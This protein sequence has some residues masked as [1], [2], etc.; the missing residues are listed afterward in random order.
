MK[1]GGLLY[2]KK[3]VRRIYRN[4]KARRLSKKDVAK[5]ALYI[6]GA[7]VLFT[8]ILFAW[9]SKDLPTPSKLASLR[10]KESTKILDRNGKLL[11][12]TGEQKRTV[13]TKEQIPDNVKKAT[14]AVEDA[15]FY[16]HGGIDF[17]GIARAV[18]ADIF[19]RNFSQGASTITQQYVKN[20]ILSPEK[21]VAR[22]VKEVILSIELE[23]LYSKDEIL[24]MYLNEIPY[25]G[26]IYGVEAASQTFFGKPANQLSLSEA[27]TL[28]AIPQ[29]PT[30]FSPYG[31]HTDALFAR[32]NLVLDRMVKAGYVTQPEAD[33]TKEQAPN[34]KEAK[35]A[36]RTDTIIA[37]HFVMYV[38]DVLAD[39]YGEQL[40]NS[41]G[42]T[43]TTTL[44]IEKQK[45]AQ[46]AIDETVPKLDRYNATNASLVSIDNKTGE[47][48]AMVGGKDYFDLEH[49]GNVNVAVSNRQPGSSFKPI[50]YATAFKQARYNPAFVLYDLGTD[51]GGYK[52]NNYNGNFNGPVTIRTALSN[53][54]NIPAVK[55]LGLVGI[56]DAIQTAKDLGITT[57]TQPERYGLSLVLGGG[58]VKLLELTGAYSA[59]GDSGNFHKP[60]SVLKVQDHREKVL[61]EYK[62]EKNKFQ[63]LDPQVAYEITSV[64]SDNNA[65]S[66]I[67]GPR[68]SLFFP[69]RHVAVKTG[70]TQSFHDA[71]TVGY[72]PSITA[73][74]WVGNNDNT[75]MR[76]G[77][78]GSVLAGP[79]FNK[80][81][82][83]VLDKDEE[84]IRPEGIQEITVD[85][86]SNKLPGQYSPENERIK[87]IFASYQVPTKF[88]DIHALFKV[89]K[90]N[91]KL[92]TDKTPSNLV[93]E[94]LFTNLHNE[95]GDKW[96]DYPNWEG[97]IRSWALGS[98]MNLTPSNEDDDSYSYN[99][100]VQIINPSNGASVSGTISI[101]VSIK[102]QYNVG[103]IKY[104][105]GDVQIGE[106]KETSISL[107]TLNYP[108]GLYTI[109]AIFEDENGVSSD[110][111]SELNIKNGAAIEI[112]SP[113][114][115]GI[116][117]SSAIIGFSTNITANSTIKYGTSQANLTGQKTSGANT[118]SHQATLTGLTPNTTYYFL[119][120]TSNSTRSAQTQGS[121]KTQ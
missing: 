66:M 23:Q 19:N 118:T 58:E 78:D 28:A 85:K 83:K 31:S 12:E 107:N 79:I 111:Q 22:K 89:N 98:G 81:M 96:K 101:Q 8:V 115:S 48:L 72:S 57:L 15:N 114:A 3:D 49:D 75:P 63:A 77:A 37:P 20:A 55:M 105:L 86:L 92:A 32:K 33:K 24:T 13:I 116:T 119:I 43:V 5:I 68:S 94:K 39:Q 59:F 108:D 69:D 88:D 102:S 121:F 11:Y 47:V 70:T 82:T 44:D 34:K 95:W 71:W 93:E 87:D 73:G 84:F 45:L 29:A 53:S 21:S 46:E 14:I 56:P 50:V 42:L 1:P 25:G 18:Y 120:E 99:P 113:A 2:I 62:K 17:R 27:A 97:P 67:F 117:A 54:L 10:A 64:L 109:K 30:R 61:F 110:A 16:K 51:F 91:N 6:V 100:T 26:N 38:K 106:T 65:R 76:G 104:R 103:S 35:F 60:T 41:G 36:K 40:V 52:P 80:Y 4:A 90:I 7:I 112:S 9:F 74:I